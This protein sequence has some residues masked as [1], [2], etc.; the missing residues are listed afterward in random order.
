[1]GRSRKQE[2][3]AEPFQRKDGE[4]AG[5]VETTGRPQKIKPVFSELDQ[6]AREQVDRVL[7]ETGSGVRQFVEY[8]AWLLSRMHSPVDLPKPLRSHNEDRYP[9]YFEATKPVFE[10]LKALTDATR[11]PLER[12]LAFAISYLEKLRSENQLE[13]TLSTGQATIRDLSRAIELLQWNQQAF[14]NK[15]WHWCCLINE[16]LLKEYNDIPQIKRFAF[17]RLGY[18]HLA[19]CTDLIALIP[20]VVLKTQETASASVESICEKAMQS[21]KASIYF[22]R[23]AC[24]SEGEVNVARYNLACAYSLFAEVTAIGQSAWHLKSE[25]IKPIR[26]AMSKCLDRKN[27]R[28]R[29]EANADARHAW[30]KVFAEN[31]RG[32]NK[33][34]GRVHGREIMEVDKALSRAVKE[35]K[36]WVK[37]APSSVIPVAPGELIRWSRIDLD[38]IFLRNDPSADIR[39]SYDAWTKSHSGDSSLLDTHKSL[40]EG[41]DYKND[42][43]TIDVFD[44]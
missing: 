28:I 42:I 11:L 44:I 30:R 41:S 1:M 15:R 18:C 4:N 35:L 7:E 23:Q 17:Y 34:G 26:D 37:S 2:T 20:E 12:L 36:D 14:I 32:M 22:S 25:G 9:V 43:K 19:L 5:E 39:E 38:L 16:R 10:Q 13:R 3:A 29:E 21:I 40:I 33:E 31:W 6:A 24:S 27:Q 8:S